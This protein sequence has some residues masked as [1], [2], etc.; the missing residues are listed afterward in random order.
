MLVDGITVTA[1]AYEDTK[2]ILHDLY[3]DRNRIIQAHL[4]YLE[5]VTPIRFASAETLNTMYIQCNRRIQAVRALGKDVKAYGRLLVPKILSAFPDDICR[6]WIIQ[7]KREG[8]S[9]G[10]VVKLMGFLGEEVDGALTVQ[11]IRGDTSPASNFTPTAATLHVRSKSGSISRKSRSVEPFCL[12][13]ERNGHWAQDCK[14]VTDVKGRVEKLKSANRCFL[15]LNRGHH[16]HAYIKRGK[17][18]C[19]RCRKGHHRSVCMDKETTSRTSSI[20]SASV[21]SVDI[22][23]PEYTYLQRARVWVTGLTGLS[24]LTRCVLDG[25][26]QCSFFARSVIDDLQ[27][28]VIEQRD[29]SVTAFETYPT[30][31]GRR[32]LVR[33]N[34]RGTGTNALTSL[35]AFESTHAFSHHHIGTLAHIRKLRLAD[36]P[37]DLKNLPIEILFAGDHYSEIVKDTPQYAFSIRRTVTI[38]VRLDSQWEPFCRNGHFDYG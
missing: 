11:K 23:S 7:V 36:P 17:V 32:R 8:H 28:E 16:T 14:A 4:D 18:F 27:L 13:C 19:S 33:F 30:A 12:F 22:S 37:G 35:T 34:M 29:L 24:R 38:E 21:G 9:E 25:G 5:E 2:K 20:T 26:N 10:D 31:P 1:S 6:R 3:G 15:C